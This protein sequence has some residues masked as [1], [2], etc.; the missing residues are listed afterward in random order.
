MSIMSTQIPAVPEFSHMSHPTRKQRLVAWLIL[1]V[2]ALGVAALTRP[3]SYWNGEIVPVGNDAF[4]HARRILDTVADPG[5]FYEFDNKI[6]APEGSLLTWPWGYD[7]LMAQVVRAGVAVGI[8][9][10]PMAILA[11]IP[12]FASVISVGLLM[13]ICAELRLSLWA[14]VLAGLCMVLAPTLQLLHGVGQIDHHFVELIYV[15]AALAFG[16]RWLNKPDSTARS[17]MLGL[18]LGSAPVFHN[19]LFV[20]QLPLLATVFVFWIQGRELNRR[21]ILILAAVLVTATLLILLP[22]LPFRLGRFEFHTL[23]WFHLYAAVASAIALAYVSSLAFSRGK[24][25]GLVALCVALLIP[26][27]ANMEHG[28]VF[29]TGNNKHLAVIGEMHPP[30]LA[31]QRFGVAILN[32]VYSLTIWLLPFTVILCLVRA[33]QDRL[34]NRLLL[35]ISSLMGLALLSLQLRLHYFG[36]FALFLPWLALANDVAVR[37]QAWSKKIFLLTTLALVLLY[38]PPLRHQIAAPMPISND[39]TFVN[40]RPIYAA[41]ANEC[42]RRPGIVLAD[43]NAGHF[44]RYYT[45][46]SVIANNF[47]M[48]PQHWAKVDEVARY[49]KLSARELLDEAPMVDYV[50]VRPIELKQQPNGQVRYKFFYAGTPQLNKDL[51]FDVPERVP[52]EYKLVAQIRFE[53]LNNAPYAKLYRIDRT[54]GTSANDVKD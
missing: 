29:L 8:S 43:A 51:L 15:L 7:Y 14:T 19:G 31:A 40:V 48:T 21:G 25:A 18:V 23:S 33:W 13:L 4:Y 41:L 28:Q 12:V 3:A 34:S 22:S 17:A 37:H 11:W 20:L 36:D 35:W 50:L 2:L 30:L 39:L 46:C 24:L 45:D 9:S 49:F 42:S 27:L 26:M 5:S 53:D 32:R 1:S 6:H 52:P 54:A 10:D 44:I 47:L 38:A 16:L